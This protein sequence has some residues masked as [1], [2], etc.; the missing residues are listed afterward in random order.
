MALGNQLIKGFLCDS[1]KGLTS[2]LSSTTKSTEFSFGRQQMPW[3]RGCH[4]EYLHAGSYSLLRSEKSDV[5]SVLKNSTEYSFVFFKAWFPFVASL[6]FVAR[7]GFS[8]A[9]FGFP[10]T[11]LDLVF[12]SS[13]LLFVASRCFSLLFVACSCSF[14]FFM[15]YDVSHLPSVQ[16]WLE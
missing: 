3:G 10:T 11:M 1:L 6:P 14:S 5:I 13:L 16:N 8:I 2:F 9:W 12:C 4:R 7:F 15:V